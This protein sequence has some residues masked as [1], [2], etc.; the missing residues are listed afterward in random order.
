M[1]PRPMELAVTLDA[2]PEADDQELDRLARQLHGEI[3]QLHV[4]SVSLKSGGAA[5]PG[6]MAGE[7]ITIGSL[8]V[9][10]ASAGVFT[11]LI[12]ML[13][14]W[15]LRKEGRT[16]KIKAQ[17]EG[18]SIEVEYSPTATSQEDMTRF[19]ESIIRTLK[20]TDSLK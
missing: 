20:P 2:G 3:E 11:A 8:I 5:P 6:T 17:V 14:G 4:E 10:L 13:K 9:S 15:A 7:E 19:V 18:R 12:E 1:N 16:I